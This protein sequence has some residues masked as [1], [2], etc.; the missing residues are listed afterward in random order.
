MD[1][2]V[3]DKIIRYLDMAKEYPVIIIEHDVDWSRT[4][5][6]GMFTGSIVGEYSSPEDL[7][8]H[9]LGKDI[10]SSFLREMIERYDDDIYHRDEGT[11]EEI[12]NIYQKLIEIKD[13]RKVLKEIDKMRV[14]FI[15]T[16]K[17]FRG[18][19]VREVLD[20]L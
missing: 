19:G 9:L 20:W 3:I 13:L 7:R 4:F 6:D 1:D 2:L 11:R 18:H 16:F 17:V 15:H 14:G 5:Y 8:D 12:E 10:R